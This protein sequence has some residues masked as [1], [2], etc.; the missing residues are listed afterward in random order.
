MEKKRLGLICKK[1]NLRILRRHLNLT[2]K[3]FINCFLSDEKGEA[4]ISIATLSNLEAKGGSRLNEVIVAVAEKLAV[5]PMIFAMDSDEF[6]KNVDIL[7]P[8]SSSVENIRKNSMK[9]GGINQLI[10]QLTIYF[11]E[12]IFEK[13]LKKGDK[14]ESDRELAVKLN[15]GRSAIREAMKVLDVMG[16]VDIRPGQGTFISNNEADFFIIPLSWSLFLN[17]NQADDIITVRNLLEIKA[18]ELAAESRDENA[19]HKL[20]EISHY[21]QKA[22]IEGHH[23]EFL[24]EDLKFHTCIAEVS[25]NHV[26]YSMIQTITNLMRHISG[27]GMILEEQFK[28]IYEEHQK[29]YG[30]ILTHDSVA[31]K[32]AMEEHLEKSRK[33]Y[34]YR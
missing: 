31:A 14:I 13:R 7:L 5:D 34:N 12:Q 15:V 16:M 22:Y 8:N 33:R 20:S 3:E 23:K 30:F 24:E 9:K 21:M 17:G 19:L 32:K 1:D 29:V 4:L 10:N 25:G 2:Q 6:A 27:S 26:I 28:E 11:A 18:A